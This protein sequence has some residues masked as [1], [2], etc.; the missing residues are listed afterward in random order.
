MGSKE[1]RKPILVISFCLEL[2]WG[3]LNTGNQNMIRR[4]KEDETAGRGTIKALLKL[5]EAFEIPVTWAVVGHLFLDRCEK[6]EGVPHPDMPRFK[7]NWYELDPCTDIGR[8]PLFYGKDLIE[9]IL[10]SKVKHEIG[11]HSFSHVIFPLATLE[12]AEAEIA[13]GVEIAQK[14]FG[15]KL[16]SFIFPQNKIAHLELLEK[17]GFVAFRGENVWEKTRRNS[18]SLLWRTLSSIRS[19]IAI[20]PI[21]PCRVGGLLNIPTSMLFD[22]FRPLPSS[23]LFG[24][25]GLYK[26][27]R[28]NKV[29]HISS[30]PESFIRNPTL[31]N[32]FKSFLFVVSRLRDRGL[33]EVSTMGNL[34]KVF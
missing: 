11:Y 4:L 5:L 33:L 26:T 28:K 24:L 30:H 7:D 29:F 12:V 27:L 21:S 31:K 10:S 6:V 9:Q 15:L 23:L 18:S 2:I 16:K 14:E 25:Y 22:T 34:A 1:N 20:G 3:Y 19:S 17:Y 13:K 32:Q 8:D